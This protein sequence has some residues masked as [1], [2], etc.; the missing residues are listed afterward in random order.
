MYETAPSTKRAAVLATP[1]VYV[2]VSV[3]VSVEP[4][5]ISKYQPASSAVDVRTTFCEPEIKVNPVAS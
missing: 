2:T 5:V 3:R 1:G 4:S